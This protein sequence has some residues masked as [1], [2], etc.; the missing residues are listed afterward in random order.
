M[1]TRDEVT[2]SIRERQEL[3]R[4]R[5]QLQA[6]DPLLARVLRSEELPDADEPTTPWSRRRRWVVAQLAR[7]WVGPVAVLV[8]LALVMVTLASLTLL[9]V[10]GALVTAAGLGLYGQTCRRRWVLRARQFP[11][12]SGTRNF[13]SGTRN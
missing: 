9:S 12:R 3:A 13:R 10:V 5:A 4:M 7:P 2:L 1:G 6:A 8:G 11:V